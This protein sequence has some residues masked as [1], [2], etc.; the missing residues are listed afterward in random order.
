MTV[1]PENG[2]NSA[3][4]ED[5]SDDVLIDLTAA[6][7]AR[8][9]VGHHKWSDWMPT[10]S[11]VIP[12]FNEEPNLPHVLPRI[13]SWVTEVIIVD[14]RSTDDTVAVAR[15]LRPDVIVLHQEG[16]GKGDAMRLGFESST[17]DII[18][19]IDADG[20]MDPTELH[21]FVGQLMGGA[22]LVKG[23]RFAQGGG[24]IDMEFHRRVGNWGLV[25]LTRFLFGQHYSDL[26]YGY[27]A[28]WSRILDVIEPDAD[29]FE[30]EA[31]INARA[32][33]ARLKIAEVPSFEARRVHGVSNLKT[34]RD[35]WRILR[36][37][38]KERFIPHPQAPVV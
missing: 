36:T 30:I 15:S 2:S 27:V 26:C 4:T 18:A 16:V 14:G 1:N 28:F 19:A 31:L 6:S 21:A 12:T 8:S 10:V 33:R 23:S 9:R 3:V 22:D 35:G 20:S 13:P 25:Q 24:T 29:G 7:S 11:L 32:L 17:G 5:D 34:F 38:L 37:L